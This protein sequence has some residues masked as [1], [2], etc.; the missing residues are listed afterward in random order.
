MH[1]LTIPGLAAALALAGCGSQQSGDSGGSAATP[2]GSGAVRPS[3][4]AQ[5]ELTVSVK[6]AP[7]AAATTWKLSC[8]P[9]GGDHPDAKAACAALAA[10]A[11]QHKDPFAPTPKGQM[12]TQIY[13]GPQVATIK[14]T[15]QGKPVDATFTRKNGCELTRWS[16]LGPMF[17]NVPP[18]R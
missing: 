4:P 17:G 18:G 12:C 15:W 2:S 7:T 3:T 14:G 13:G 9:V 16:N 1:I 5:T 6:G 11:K 10:A 8:D